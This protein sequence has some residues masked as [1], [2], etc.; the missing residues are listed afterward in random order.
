MDRPFIDPR[1]PDRER[2]IADP[3]GYA[4]LGVDRWRFIK[5]M[6]G[7]HDSPEDPVSIS[8]LNDP[9]LWLSQSQAITAAAVA[10]MKVQP[11]FDHLPEEFHGI[12]DGQVCATI[13]MLVGYSLEVCCKAV[14]LLEEGPESADQFT[15]HKIQELVKYVGPLDEKQEIILG[16]LTEHC[17]WAGRYPSPKKNTES[18]ERIHKLSTQ[19]EITAGDLFATAGHVQK[20]CGQKIQSWL[21]CH[22]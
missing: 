11:N 9:M 2:F 15:H 12:L 6:N 17:Y 18:F 16:L 1:V 5:A 21:S 7:G 4:G 14:I 20:L 8:D 10:L 13:L 3:F 22:L 19:Y